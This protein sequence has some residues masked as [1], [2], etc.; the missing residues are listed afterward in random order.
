MKN[1]YEDIFDLMIENNMDDTKKFF[2]SSE[3]KGSEIILDDLGDY[4]PFIYYLGK[5]DFC[6]KHMRAVMKDYPEGLIPTRKKGGFYY[7]NIYEYSDFLLGLIDYYKDSN[8][9]KVLKYTIRMMD[10]VI[11]EFSLEKK[12]YSFVFHIGPK[13]KS[14]P[15]RENS[16]GFFI[17]ILIEMH[18]T[19]E[20]DK[21]LQVAYSLSDTLSEDKFFRK[22]YILPEYTGI[23]LPKDMKKIRIMK[24]NTN[25]LYGFLELYK[26][27]KEWGNRKIIDKWLSRM[28]DLME[29]KPSQFYE[30]KGKKISSTK[31]YLLPA[32]FAM[33]DFICDFTYFTGEREFLEKAKEIADEWIKVRG[34]TGLFPNDFDEKRSDLDSN[35]DFAVALA[36]LGQLCEEPKY[37]EIAKDIIEAQKKHHFVKRRGMV[38]GVHID[39]GEVLG[40]TIKTK[41][42]FLFFKAKILEDCGYVV[43]DDNNLKAYDLLK[44]R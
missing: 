38:L 18:K 22:Y 44:D 10:K 42:N 19:T 4:L 37:I 34:K 25:S 29:A 41:F 17:E 14:I 39:T 9:K 31:Q 23:F 21:Y 26:H 12:P 8:D 24:T 33:I 5:T 7:S 32:S 6:K 16:I 40:H 15:V 28:F 30:I 43:Y 1:I 3:K 36:K 20:D 35:T 13:R 11:D 27:T 2:L